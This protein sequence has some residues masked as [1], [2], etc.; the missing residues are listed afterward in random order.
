MQL[1]K[2]LTLKKKNNNNKRLK[3]R[4]THLK[5]CY[6]V[7]KWTGRE[8]YQAVILEVEPQVF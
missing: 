1:H 6:V 2:I 5:K 3:W 8:G 7:D 4:Y